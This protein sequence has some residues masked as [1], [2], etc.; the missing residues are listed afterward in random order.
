MT[1]NIVDYEKLILIHGPKMLLCIAL[2]KKQ[3]RTSQVGAQIS[4]FHGHAQED[5]HVRVSNL[6]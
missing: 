2:K 3:F 4:V 6:K 5:R 1:Q